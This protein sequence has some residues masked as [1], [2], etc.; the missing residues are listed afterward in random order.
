[1]AVTNNNST[2]MKDGKRVIWMRASSL[3]ELFDCPS[4]WQANNTNSGIP[5]IP[6]SL[7]GHAGSCVH[8]ATEIYDKKYL[9][10]L[11]PQTPNA[12]FLKRTLDCFNLAFDQPE[13]NVRETTPK[14]IG[15]VRKVG[16]MLVEKYITEVAPTMMYSHIEVKCKPWEVDV[17]GVILSLTGTI[18]RI[19]MEAQGLNIGNAASPI[20]KHGIADIKT[21][22]QA[23]NAQNVVEVESHKPQLG[24]YEI[25]GE[26]T[27][28]APIDADAKI[29]GMQTNTKAR[30]AIGS[31]S[32]ARDIVLGTQEDVGMLA[33]AGLLLEHSIFYGNPSSMMCS[34]DYC[35]RYKTC[36]FR[37]ADAVEIKEEA[38]HVVELAEANKKERM[39]SKQLDAAKPKL[40]LQSMVV[41]EDTPV[42]V[43]LGMDDALDLQQLLV[44]S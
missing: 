27:I 4:R 38:E 30:V 43:D 20:Y 11:A 42:D 6:T 23:V 21:G 37:G 5:A 25:L 40:D 14:D 13:Y 7:K 34:P 44:H 32:S 19:Y 33:N 26:K 12:E 39:T 31:T 29:I 8:K 2:V 3:K 24:L 15:D 16:L 1:M 35:R 17:G 28:K 9:G 18:D 22:V 10:R 36:R 41:M